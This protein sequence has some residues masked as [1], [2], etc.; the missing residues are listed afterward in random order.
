M[1]FLESGKKTEWNVSEEQHVRSG[2]GTNING[3]TEVY[4]AKM[5]GEMAREKCRGRMARFQIADNCVPKTD[6]GRNSGIPQQI[7]AS[8]R[9][10]AALSTSVSRFFRSYVIPDPRSL[11]LPTP[12]FPKQRGRI[13]ASAQ[14]SATIGCRVGG[15]TR[16]HT[17]LFS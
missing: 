6:Q 17:L 16:I 10:P 1:C 13:S 3:N 2:V 5:R 7:S 12:A 4:G 14:L 8:V 15:D 9:G 11:P